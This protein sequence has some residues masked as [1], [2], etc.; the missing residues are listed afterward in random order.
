MGMT[1]DEQLGYMQNHP[2]EYFQTN[3]W[4]ASQ[5]ANAGY[6]AVGITS[7][8][9]AQVMPEKGILMMVGVIVH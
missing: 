6:F 3:A 4:T 9:V 7:D 5:Y 1:A 2:G 8:H